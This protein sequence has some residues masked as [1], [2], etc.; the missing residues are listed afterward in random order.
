MGNNAQECTRRHQKDH[1]QEECLPPLPS[2]PLPRHMAT[3]WEYI[4][5][6]ISIGG[7]PACVGS[8]TLMQY[9]L[10]EVTTRE[11]PWPLTRWIARHVSPNVIAVS[12]LIASLPFVVAP[13]LLGAA[14][15]PGQIENLDS[16]VFASNMAHNSLVGVIGYL[17]FLLTASLVSPLVERMFSN[18][19]HS[20]T[21]SE[22][23]RGP[24]EA[25][26][27]LRR[28][29][30]TVILVGTAAFALLCA[31]FYAPGL[32]L[33]LHLKALHPLV[34]AVGLSI[35]L[36]L[37]GR[38]VW[39]PSTT[40]PPKLGLGK[41][42]EFMV[43]T[44]TALVI[45]GFVFWLRNAAPNIAGYVGVFPTATSVVLYSVMAKDGAAGMKALLRGL[46]CGACGMVWFLAAL[47]SLLKPGTIAGSFSLA[48]LAAVVAAF[49]TYLMINPDQRARFFSWLLLRLK[50]LVSRE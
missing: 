13:M 30:L 35:V 25:T 49:S 41:W 40:P 29:S 27:H 4:S 12:G 11:A 2:K 10:K 37:L 39:R 36:G 5:A 8:I 44:G 3:T 6:T 15:Q 23:T 43:R 48:A 18:E 22:T 26:R 34:L 20:S 32:T 47:S 28:A 7:A 31:V 50:A 14:L 17:S 45:S 1:S 9:W 46:L 21:S 42:N 33:G 38:F 19:K 24:H 16:P